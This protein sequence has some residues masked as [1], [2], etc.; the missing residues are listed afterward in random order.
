MT[1]GKIIGLTIA[2]CLLGLPLMLWL[3]S[4]TKPEPLET[5]PAPSPPQQPSMATTAAT[6][7]PAPAVQTT[8]PSEPT[9]FLWRVLSTEDVSTRTAHRTVVKISIQEGLTSEQL[10]L[11]LR[12]I[13]EY[14]Y[15]G[16]GALM[17]HAYREGTGPDGA[18]TA[19]KAV[20]AP[21]G[22]WENAA[23]GAG[24]E[25]TVVT[26]EPSYFSPLPPAATIGKRGKA[27]STTL[28][29]QRFPAQLS[30][31]ADSWEDRDILETLRDGEEVEV[32][33]TKRYTFA[34]GLTLDRVRV[35]LVREPHIEGWLMSG[36][37]GTGR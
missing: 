8:R 1:G 9:G 20:R 19:A 35:R 27:Q 24:M 12:Q 36:E 6:P 14:L 5:A 2:L 25:R 37:V 34:G 10:D 32:L 30:R 26:A 3:L 28:G 31:V 11:R 18:Y 15:G 13:A 4:A 17:I 23:A 29:G 21:Y 33:E 22:N 16:S 7:S